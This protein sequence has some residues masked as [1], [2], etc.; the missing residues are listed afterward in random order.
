[1]AVLKLHYSGSFVSREGHTVRAEIWAPGTA[2][3]VGDLT[4]NADEPVVV[5][6]GEMDKET[7]LMGSS[8]T[9][10]IISPGDRTY[11]HL[12]T[13]AAGSM[14]LRLYLYGRLFWTGILYT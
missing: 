8:A 5:E 13:T 9:I 7:T 2:G 12:Y 4:F 3:S 14:W 1:M 11:T 10:N 6:W